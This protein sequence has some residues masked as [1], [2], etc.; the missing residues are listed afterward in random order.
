[1]RFF[2]SSTF[3]TIIFPVSIDFSEIAQVFIFILNKA[4]I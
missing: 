1:M 3:Y 2:T 4:I